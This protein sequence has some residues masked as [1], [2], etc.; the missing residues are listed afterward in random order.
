MTFFF[1][2]DIE[3]NNYSKFKM[4][5]IISI[6]YFLIKNYYWQTKN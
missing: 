6:M 5:I 2:C 3:I 4:Q 1:I